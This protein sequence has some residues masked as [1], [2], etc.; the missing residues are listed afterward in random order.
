MTGVQTCAL[1]IS[2]T[3]V[4]TSTTETNIPPNLAAR[5][6]ATS[7]G[8]LQVVNK[9]ILVNGAVQNISRIYAVTNKSVLGWRNVSTTT[10]GCGPGGNGS[11]C[12]TNAG[13]TYKTLSTVNDAYTAGQVR[14]LKSS[15]NV[16]VAG[17]YEVCVVADLGDSLTESSE[18][19]NKACS[20]VTV[21]S[22]GVV[23]VLTPLTPLTI[24]ATPALIRKGQTSTIAWNSGGRTQCA[25]TSTTGQTEPF[26]QG[27]VP[28]LT[29]S[30]VTTPL[31]TPA[32]VT[33][34][35]TD[36][37]G[38]AT[39]AAQVKLLPDIKEI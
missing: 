26:V 3:Y 2:R 37:G 19:D 11:V 8:G 15:F 4:A 24:T 16:S 13:H 18:S 29:G 1:P 32:N 10:K 27:G 34:T 35:C 6:T 23:T 7:T 9:L 12:F 39:A 36:P 17:T 30:Y 28:R 20:M 5:L 33:I 38:A 25:L 31:Q 22:T 14:A 21:T